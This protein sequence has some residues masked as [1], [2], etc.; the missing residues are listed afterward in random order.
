MRDYVAAPARPEYEVEAVGDGQAALEAAW[1]R[2]P[3]LVLSDIMMPRLDGFSLLKALRNDSKLRD[4][5][6][7]FLSARAGEEAK[8]EGLGSRR[9]RLSQQAVQRA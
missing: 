6:V 4:V 1:R 2:R 9:R 7:I 3:D 8:V 5:P